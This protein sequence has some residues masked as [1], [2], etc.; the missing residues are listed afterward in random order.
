MGGGPWDSHHLTEMIAVI[1]KVI[2]GIPTF[3]KNNDIQRAPRPDR[4]VLNSQQLI[5]CRD[6][7]S[8]IYLPIRQYSIYQTYIPIHLQDNFRSSKYVGHD[9]IIVFMVPKSSLSEVLRGNKCESSLDHVADGL[10][11]ALL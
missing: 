8:K 1:E 2:S 6:K 4:L 5:V 10:W 11:D 3:E 7:E 9:I